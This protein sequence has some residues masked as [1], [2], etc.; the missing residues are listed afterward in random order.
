MA[1]FEDPSPPA[2]VVVTERLDLRRLAADDAEFILELVNEPAWL[3]HIGDKGVRTLAD[4]RAYI[5]EGPVRTYERFGF[6]LYLVVR[7]QDGTALGIC[8][9]V[10]R[11]TLDDVDLGFALLRRHWGEGY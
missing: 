3:E 8:G 7:R 2:I 10:K 9:L 4:A 1:A 11:E 5:A 6:G